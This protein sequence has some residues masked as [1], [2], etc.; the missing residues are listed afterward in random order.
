MRLEE[1]EGWRIKVYAIVYG[2]QPFDTKVHEEGLQVAIKAL[3]Q[4]A[5]CEF[6]PG[7]G[8][9]ICHQRCGVHYLVLGWTDRINEM[10]TRFSVSEFGANK[11][12]RPA[13]GSE[14][15]CV[16]DIEVIWFEKQ[17]YVRTILTND[18]PNL[19]EYLSQTLQV[20]TSE[21]TSA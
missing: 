6:R 9:A 8:F 16:W 13:Q 18:G 4:P 2:D 11:T 14:S 7:V 17:A 19:D 20:D 15:V 10:S 5:V 1:R 12:W 3:P 21:I